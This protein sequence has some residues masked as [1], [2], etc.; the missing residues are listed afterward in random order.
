MRKII[1]S[2]HGFIH[3]WRV[4]GDD[5]FVAKMKRLMETFVLIM[6]KMLLPMKMIMMTITLMTVMI[7]LMTMMR[8]IK[9]MQMVVFSSLHR[10][11]LQLKQRTPVS[12]LLLLLHVLFLPLILLL[13]PVSRLLLLLPAKGFSAL[14]SSPSPR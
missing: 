13:L 14:S 3:W 1:H 7:M 2:F 4:T 9:M 12:R 10:R 11:R 6:V 8:N 5:D